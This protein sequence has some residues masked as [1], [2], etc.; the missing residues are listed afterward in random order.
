MVMFALLAVTGPILHFAH[1]QRHQRET[2]NFKAPRWAPVVALNAPAPRIRV[3]QATQSEFARRPAPRPIRPPEQAERRPAPRPVRP[4][5]PNERLVQALQQ[6]VDR[7]QTIKRPE[8]NAVPPPARRA[9]V[10]VV[11][12][13]R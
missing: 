1:R 11:K 12:S 4:P 2:I 8:P 5:E 13:A 3:S 10:D 9:G 7:M 6:L